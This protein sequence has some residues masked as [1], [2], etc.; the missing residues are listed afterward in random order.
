LVVHQ[1]PSVTTVLLFGA[2][3][4]ITGTFTIVFIYAPEVSHG[5]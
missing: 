2:R 1:S 5:S 3:I 4:C